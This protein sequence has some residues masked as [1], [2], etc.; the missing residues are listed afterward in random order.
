MTYTLTLRPASATD[1]PALWEL[2]RDVV[3]WLRSIG[4]DQWSGWESWLEPD[5]KLTVPLRNERCWVLTDRGQVVGTITVDPDG[6][7]DFWTPAELAESALYV[8]KLAVA[9]HLAGQRIGEALLEWARDRAWRQG[10]RWVRLDAWRTNCRLR[11][12]YVTRGWH[13]VRDAHVTDRGSG[14]LYQRPAVPVPVRKLPV[15]ITTARRHQTAR[16]GG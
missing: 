16:E 12:Y 15:E 1:A 14:A 10:R 8:S 2:I 7:P 6:D 5:G 13:W 3:T 9:R 11:D 4:S